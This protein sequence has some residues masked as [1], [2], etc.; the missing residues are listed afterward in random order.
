MTATKEK[1]IIAQVLYAGRAATSS[2]DSDVLPFVAWKEEDCYRLEHISGCTDESREPGETLEFGDKVVLVQDGPQWL[3]ECI[4][5]DLAVGTVLKGQV[6]APF[7]GKKVRALVELPEYR[8]KIMIVDCWRELLMREAEGR[9]VH[10]TVIQER[11]LK[12]KITGFIGEQRA[13][14]G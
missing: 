5:H 14:A 6:F 2:S 8:T 10:L 12:L 9:P 13:K 1:K 11:P 7:D 4:Y 3:M